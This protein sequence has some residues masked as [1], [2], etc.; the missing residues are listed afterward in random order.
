MIGGFILG[1]IVTG[2]T[3]FT[4]PLVPD[5]INNLLEVIF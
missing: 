1:S 5:A 3:V 4:W 2:F